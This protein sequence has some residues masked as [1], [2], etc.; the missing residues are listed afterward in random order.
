MDK[1]ILTRDKT[2]YLIITS[3][4]SFILLFFVLLIMIEHI[5]YLFFLII[6]CAIILISF[7]LILFYKIKTKNYL[8]LNKHYIYDNIRKINIY[9]DRTQ[10][11]KLYNGDRYPLYYSI[12][13]ND[14]E[15]SK[16][17]QFYLSKK[18][19]K[20]ISDFYN[21][22]LENFISKKNK[23]KHFKRDLI[24]F[25]KQYYLKIFFVF[26]G[27]ALTILSFLYFNKLP[28]LGLK[29]I[30]LVCLYLIG[31]FIIYY[32]RITNDFDKKIK[33]F[34]I[35]LL[36]GL[37]FIVIIFVVILILCRKEIELFNFLCYS[38]FLLPSFYPIVVII[39]L[40]LS[41]A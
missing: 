30:V 19:I 10:S 9:I 35:S 38:I 1:K 11:I 29:I 24:D 6:F 28:N 36:V 12:I 15:T 40:C 27:I 41:A 3:I 13:I 8:I 16:D 23:N 5:N 20:Q 21:L 2:L 39:L 33:W 32:M 34:L 17:K 26:L 22:K 4:I 18:R 31:S 14:Y 37:I 25:I 7:I